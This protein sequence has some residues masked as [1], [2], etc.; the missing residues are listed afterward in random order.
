MTALQ[1]FGTKFTATGVDSTIYAI[2]AT[3]PGPD[4]GENVNDTTLGN[5]DVQTSTPATLHKW[6][7][8]EATFDAEHFE[9]FMNLLVGKTPTQR[10]LN[11]TVTYPGGGTLTDYWGNIATVLPQEDDA[12]TN[13]H[14]STVRVTIRFCGR[15]QSGNEVVPSYT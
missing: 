11:W 15:D 9:T 5:T 3:R 13:N 1:G 12:E 6:S 10:K 4:S 14:R 8:I 2:K 7:D